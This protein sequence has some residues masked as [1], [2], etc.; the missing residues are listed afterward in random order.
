MFSLNKLTAVWTVL[1]C[2]YTAIWNCAS[3]VP[4]QLSTIRSGCVNMTKTCQ[5]WAEPCH[6]GPAHFDKASWCRISSAQHLLTYQYKWY[7]AKSVLQPCCAK[8]WA[9]AFQSQKH[10]TAISRLCSCIQ[11]IFVTSCVFPLLT[12]ETIN[13]LPQWINIMWCATR[14]HTL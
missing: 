6:A 2:V 4:A 9:S 12:E 10:V 11:C 5:H 7:W 8:Y 1:Y 13:R 3:T 14:H